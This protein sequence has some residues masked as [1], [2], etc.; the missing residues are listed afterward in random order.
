MLYE[1]MTLAIA[2]VVIGLF[3]AVP[4]IRNL[5]RRDSSASGDVIKH[6]V[7]ANPALIGII[8]FPIVVVIGAMIWMYYYP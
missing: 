1:L 8:L 7:A 2:V 4:Q 3:W 6:P 5:N